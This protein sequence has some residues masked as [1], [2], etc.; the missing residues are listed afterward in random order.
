MA[1]N[2]IFKT[3]VK[4]DESVKEAWRN[5]K[6]VFGRVSGMQYALCGGDKFA[7]KETTNGR[8]YTTNC[9][10]EKYAE[11]IKLVEE[12]YPGMCEFDYKEN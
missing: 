3:L 9:N 8:I 5:N 10:P 1:E 2:R 7:N 6:Y 12:C 11:F 4:N